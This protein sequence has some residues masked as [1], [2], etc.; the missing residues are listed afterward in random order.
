MEKK[1]KKS[2]LASLSRILVAVLVISSWAVL[3]V[4]LALKSAN[5]NMSGSISFK[6]T[7]VYASVSGSVTGGSASVNKTFSTLEIDAS[8]T[9]DAINTALSNGG[10]TNINLAFEGSETITI[11][12]TITNKATDRSMWI[13]FDDTTT[14]DNVTITRTQGSET[15][16]SNAEILKNESL[17]I[18]MS[19]KVENLND[20]ASGT[21]GLGINLT[22]TNPAN[23]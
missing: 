9:Q 11:S 15:S 19:F 4:A 22:S 21:F 14:A 13:S 10:W 17:T 7:N 1:Q 12:V 6:A 3:G 8:S 23:A 2:L 16:F 20:A 5:V 18:T